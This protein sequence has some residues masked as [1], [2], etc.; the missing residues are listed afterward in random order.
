MGHLQKTVF[1]VDESMSVEG[2]ECI[3]DAI[4]R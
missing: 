2:A 3:G 4:C 1:N